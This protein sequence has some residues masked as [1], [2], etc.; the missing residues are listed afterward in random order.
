MTPH[1]KSNALY[2]VGLAQIAPVYLN[3]AAT[4]EKVIK[5]I[6][7]AGREDCRLVAFGEALVPGYPIWVEKLHGA[8]FN[9]DD[10]KRMHRCYVEQSVCIEDGHLDAVRSAAR[11]ANCAVV[12]GIIERPRDRGGHSIYASRVY[13]DAAGGIGSVHRKLMPTYEERLTWSVGDGAGLVSHV[14]GPFTLTS[15]NCWENWM[16]LARTAC[17]AAGSNLHVAIWPGSRRNTQDIT[18]F[19]A[20]EGRLYAVS[21]GAPLR[22]DDLP[23]D[24][25]YRAMLLDDASD[26]IHDGGSCLAGPDGQWIVEP[27]AQSERLIVAALDPAR[28]L[29]ERQNFDPVGHYSRPDVLHLIV[30]RRRQVTAGW[31]DP[32]EDA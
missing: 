22:P 5:T 4:L 30:D 13:V 8:R 18:R 1:H 12:L 21:V 26:W 19:I 24:V 14:A 31:I 9:N 3:R 6:A 27:I 7:E 11:S 10:V 2:R 25:P 32:D 17:Y 16:P 20:M 15:L 28:I 23:D 29:E